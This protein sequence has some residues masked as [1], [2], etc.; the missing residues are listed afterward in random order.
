MAVKHDVLPTFTTHFCSTGKLTL[1]RTFNN[2]LIKKKK[3][4]KLYLI[5]YL[6][7]NQENYPFTIVITAQ[8]MSS[9]VNSDIN[10]DIMTINQN[11]YGGAVREGLKNGGIPK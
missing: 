9:L 3:T 8:S 1:N 2:I 4:L 6:R 10:I 7:Y 11:Q 5:N